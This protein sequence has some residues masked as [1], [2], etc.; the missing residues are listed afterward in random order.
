MKP[1]AI[2]AGILVLLAAAM[3]GSSGCGS[4]DP[5]GIVLE[6]SGVIEAGDLT[7]PD[8]MGFS[9]DAYRFQARKWDRVTA[10]VATDDFPALLKLVEVSTGAPLAEWDQQYPVG[11]SLTYTIAGPGEYE[12]RVYAMRG[13]TG[14]YS[15]RIAVNR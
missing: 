12:I 13:G 3:T 11:D 15:V 8:H 4:S 2:P 1:H 5:P 14:S 10:S 7:D 6:E 9:Y